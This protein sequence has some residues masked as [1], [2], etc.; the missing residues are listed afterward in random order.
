ML[1]F[2]GSR[3]KKDVRADRLQLAPRRR[4]GGDAA[5]LPA[6]PARLERGAPRGRGPLRRARARRDRRAAAGRGRATSTTCTASAPPSATGSR[7]R[8]PRPGSASRPTTTRRFTSSRRSATSATARVTSRE[9]EKAARE[10]L[11]LPMW[12]GISEEQQAEVVSVCDAPR[13]SCGPDGSSRARRPRRDP[14]QDRVPG[15][16]APHLAARRRRRR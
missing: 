16:A 13:A 7:R 3:A 10:N 1:R 11:C 9:T 4:P 8:S 2:H 6:A 14:L 15:H 5:D 12:A